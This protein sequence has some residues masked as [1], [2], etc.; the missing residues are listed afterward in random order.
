MISYMKI[1]SLFL[2]IL[3]FS[4]VI[5]INKNLGRQGANQTGLGLFVQ[6]LSA[7][8]NSFEKSVDSFDHAD[9]FQNNKQA[10]NNYYKF[11]IQG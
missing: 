9:E 5:S 7:E 2:I 1:N 4:S 8:L 3:L 6:K 11:I 10:L